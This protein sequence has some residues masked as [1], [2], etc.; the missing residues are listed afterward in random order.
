ML[1]RAVSRNDFINLI[2][3]FG[4]KRRNTTLSM[5]FKSPI[6]SSECLLM[7]TNDSIYGKIDFLWSKNIKMQLRC[8]KQNIKKKINCL[9]ETDIG[10]FREGRWWHWTSLLSIFAQRR[11]EKKEF[12]IIYD[13]HLLWSSVFVTAG[14]V[15]MKMRYPKAKRQKKS[16]NERSVWRKELWWTIWLP[17]ELIEFLI[18]RVVECSFG[19]FMI[20]WNDFTKKVFYCYLKSVFKHFFR[21]RGVD[22]ICVFRKCQ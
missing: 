19:I 10:G 20:G 13:D 11:I 15:T 14:L 8:H 3:A 9:S 7:F 12:R 5:N 22:V 6:S 4:W 16:F 18:S 17:N 21:R 2:F 1:C